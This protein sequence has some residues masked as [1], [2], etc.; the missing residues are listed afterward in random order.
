[1]AYM[2]KRRR[3]VDAARRRERRPSRGASAAPRDRDGRPLAVDATITR[4]P[5]ARA[6]ALV[7]ARSHRKG[8]SS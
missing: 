2:A 1:M 8:T 4:L 7:L 6:L 5:R 3:A